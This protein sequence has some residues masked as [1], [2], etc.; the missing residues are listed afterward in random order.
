MEKNTPNSGSHVT[1]KKKVVHR[2]SIILAHVTYVH[3]DD[4]LTRKI[5]Q[6][7]LA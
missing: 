5:I 1:M 4:V 3:H 7:D 6:N 2:F